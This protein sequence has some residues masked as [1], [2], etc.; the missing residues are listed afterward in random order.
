MGQLVS[1]KQYWA[2][3]VWLTVLTALEVGV[4]Y[5]PVAK[6]LTIIALLSLAL[7]KA[8]LVANYYM[9]LGHET[10]LLRRIIAYCM[11][12]PAVYAMVLIV[13]ATWRMLA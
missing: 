2:I 7:A 5:M 10:R 13:E 8:A 1:R 12:L 6:T 3:F 9:H 11:A 4:A